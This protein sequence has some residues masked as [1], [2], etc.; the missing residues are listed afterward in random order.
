MGYYPQ[1][2][3]QYELAEPLLTMLVSSDDWLKTL[4]GPKDGLEIKTAS[5]GP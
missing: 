2:R 5:L 4:P 3:Y 1:P